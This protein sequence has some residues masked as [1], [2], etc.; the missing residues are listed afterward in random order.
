LPANL[1]LGDIL[2]NKFKS[3]DFKN[4]SGKSNYCFGKNKKNV[5]KFLCG[6]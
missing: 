3:L 5:K 6:L 2:K 1:A 4:M